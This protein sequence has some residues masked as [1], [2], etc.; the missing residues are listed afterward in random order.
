[1]CLFKLLKKEKACTERA[2]PYGGSLGCGALPVQRIARTALLLL[3]LPPALDRSCPH[4]PAGATGAFLGPAAWHCPRQRRG[5]AV[6]CHRPP[7]LHRVGKASAPGLVGRARSG[8]QGLCLA[9]AAISVTHRVSLLY[10]HLAVCGTAIVLRSNKQ[11]VCAG[12][13]AINS[14]LHLV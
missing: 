5:I 2:K 1:M 10:F 14:W 3:S 6:L 9:A 11:L 8:L 12:S 13:T 7:A 4:A